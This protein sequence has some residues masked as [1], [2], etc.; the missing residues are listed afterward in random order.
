MFKGTKVV[1]PDSSNSFSPPEQQRNIGIEKESFF[2]VQGHLRDLAG[3]EFRIETYFDGRNGFIEP[4]IIETHGSLGMSARADLHVLPPYRKTG[5]ALLYIT[6][7]DNEGICFAYSLAEVIFHVH[8]IWFYQ[9]RTH[10]GAVDGHYANTILIS[11][12]P[13]DALL[14]DAEFQLVKIVHFTINETVEV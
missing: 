4:A 2:G 12:A 1:L 13:D 6:A 14:A 11:L 5:S 3:I 7:I 10:T 8:V 9:P